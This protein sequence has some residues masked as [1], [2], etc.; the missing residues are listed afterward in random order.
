MRFFLANLESGTKPKQ[1]VSYLRYTRFP[2]LGP[3]LHVFSRLAMVTTFSALATG[4]N[5]GGL[6]KYKL[7]R[8]L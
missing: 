5:S 2:A 3:R 4:S 6:I 1:T 7:Y 8:F